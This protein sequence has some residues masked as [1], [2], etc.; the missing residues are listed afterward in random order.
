MT[1]GCRRNFAK[2]C[3]LRV[4]QGELMRKIDISAVLAVAALSAC[5][6]QTGG[7]I[8]TPN[9]SGPVDPSARAVFTLAVAPGSVE[10]CMLADSSMTRP[11]TV[12]VRNDK[13]LFETDGGIHDELT[14]I[15]PDVY[16]DNFQS[17][18]IEMKIE[19]DFSTRPRRLNVQTFDGTCKWTATAP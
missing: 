1:D 8:P 15:R 5:C 13:A 18:L 19:A 2:R 6:T 9:L 17:G 11:I 14:R 7:N 12:T 16:F 4:E 10:G 3:M